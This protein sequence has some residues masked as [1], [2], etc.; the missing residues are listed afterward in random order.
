VP[1]SRRHSVIARVLLIAGLAFLAW[2]LV[3]AVTGGFRIELGPARIS[4]RN[5]SRVFMLALLALAA[6]WRLAYQDHVE[7]WM[8][9]HAGRIHPLAASIAWSAAA[10][11]LVL[12]I[13][14]GS[15]SAAASDP[16]GY[17]SQSALWQQRTL[18][19]DYSFTLSLPW[20]EAGQT[21]APL[22]YKMA[23]GEVMVPTYAPG[24][25]LLMALGRLASACGPFLVGP[26][27]GAA[28][29]LW[30]FYLGRNL[31]GPAPAA[32][33]AV[34]VAC[35]PVVLF[36]AL[37]PMADV[38]AAAF[39]T[40]ALA[41]GTGAARKHALGAGVLTGVGILIRPNLAP[42]A[43]FPWLMALART[44][45]MR[46]GSTRT[47][48]F[49]AGCVPCALFV[50]WLNN[51]LYGSPF[52]SG[53]GG[54][55]EAFSFA[56]AGI[57][58][59]HYLHWW[60]ESQGPLAFFFVAGLWRHHARTR[61]FVIA[62][63]YV[64]ALVLLYVFYLPFEAWWFLRF[65]LPAVPFAFLL[66]ADAVWRLAGRSA[67][68]QAVALV[69]FVAIAGAHALRF[70]DL[71]QITR[72]GA[73]EERYIEPALYMDANIPPDAVVLTVH[74]SGSVRYYAGR[75][76][77]RWDLLDP[78]WLDQ[79]V[80]ELRRRQIPVYLL[81]EHHEVAQFKDRFK[82]QRT[83]ERLTLPPIAVGR[84]GEQ[85]LFSL[86]A[87]GAPI[88][89]QPAE[90]PARTRRTCLEMSPNFMTPPAVTRLK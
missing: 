51:H 42:L 66:G 30:T 61:E 17:V 43:I 56:N 14:S 85:Q 8:Q 2:A 12:G 58:T 67:T 82:E 78:A 31:F 39:W 21:L 24:L 13:V 46:E 89:A 90:I 5:S 4:S 26:A 87:S 19:I 15:R 53:Y 22:G 52:T 88:H 80:E 7:A 1:H 84:S 76:T 11:V 41:L 40:G 60:W 20:P 45:G 55:G 29:V 63:V 81:L 49:A 83:L 62:L 34:L 50:G 23:D 71:Q 37:L 48:L 36:M 59:R 6:A 74:H 3:I 69:A 73:G 28:L 72:I 86:D 33:A 75:L 68:I 25:P 27:C 18:R 10:V 38:P 35:S 70:N 79:A 44:R 57:N 65:L 32:A 9:R 16:F 54:L 64:A 77:L 47:L